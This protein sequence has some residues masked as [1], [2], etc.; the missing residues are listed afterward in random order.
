MATS[1]KLPPAVT[2]EWCRANFPGQGNKLFNK[3]AN[4]GGYGSFTEREQLGL[5]LD[6]TGLTAE[7]RAMVLAE[8]A[9]IQSTTKE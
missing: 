7:A 8:I 5:S 3:I 9:K 2:P 4:I 1:F 6:L